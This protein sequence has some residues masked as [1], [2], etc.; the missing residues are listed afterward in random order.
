LR[1]VIDF[2]LGFLYT[3]NDRA[4]RGIGKPPEELE[5]EQLR[6]KMSADVKTFRTFFWE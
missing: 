4:F 5:P 3:I 1:R 2:S 6:S